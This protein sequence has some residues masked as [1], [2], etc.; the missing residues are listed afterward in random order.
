[1]PYVACDP[2][3]FDD[4]VYIFATEALCKD[5]VQGLSQRQIPAACPSTETPSSP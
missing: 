3:T 5:F 1:M 2:E 4:Q